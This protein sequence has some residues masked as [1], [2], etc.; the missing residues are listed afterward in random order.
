MG[1][2]SL[3]RREPKLRVGEPKLTPA[4]RQ[5][6]VEAA[7]DGWTL[8]ELADEY[9]V[10]TKTIQ[11]VLRAARQ[12]TQVDPVLTLKRQLELKTV[13]AQLDAIESDPEIRARMVEQLVGPPK[14]RPVDQVTI[15][16][17]IDFLGKQGRVVV[18]Q[19]WLAD[20]EE[21]A[22]QQQEALQDAD[23][24]ID[25]LREQLRGATRGEG[26]MDDVLRRAADVLLPRIA[27]SAPGL[28]APARPPNGAPAP[29][30]APGAAPATLD[31]LLANV[32][33]LEPAEAARLVY[34]NATLGLML[35]GLPLA[36]AVLLLLSTSGP[37][38]VATLVAGL[39]ELEVLH[40]AAVE[41]PE[42]VRAFLEALR[43]EHAARTAAQAPE[44]AAEAAA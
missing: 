39:A 18:D 38:E 14:D 42:W 26:A 31:A 20:L 4:Q 28:P 24:E 6:I 15:E 34:T 41:R 32:L 33:A 23:A 13:Q 37:E 43:Q 8:D 5:E 25:E 44:A 22:R 35:G 19:R 27:A 2:F 17:V 21:R 16:R 1:L 11:R 40:R 30:P 7:A 29:S 9:D 3:F 36:D 12:A 10:S